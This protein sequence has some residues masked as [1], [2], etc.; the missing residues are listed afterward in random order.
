MHMRKKKWSRPELE[1]C[2]YFVANPVQLRN[3][4]AARFA[5]QQP[6]HIE[7]GCGK[8][9]S[10]AQMTSANRQINYLAIDINLDVLGCARRNLEAAYGD[11]PIENALLTN[12][13]I[14]YIHTILGPE[15]RVERIYISFCNPWC[16]RPKQHKRRLTHPRQLMQYREFLADGGEIWFKTDDDQLFRDSLT[17][18]S[19]C[20]FDAAYL[21]DDLHGSGFA[22]NYVSEYE[23]KYLASGMKIHFGIFRK[24]PGKL[25]LDAVAWREW[26]MDDMDGEEHAVK[27]YTVKRVV[28][29]DFGCEGLPDGEEL[30]VTLLLLNAEGAPRR[31]RMADA[32]A[33]ALGIC[34]GTRLAVH[35]DGAI[36]TE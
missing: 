27:H 34:E 24:R 18:F 14:E 20:G 28:E 22:P 35:A 23:R 21:T 17:Y 6:F 31:L 9:V 4:W 8:G 7:L 33:Q 12:C 25:E 5:H 19:V 26:E 30:Q 36:T 1:A 32:Q 11:D 10:T 29:D 3:A 13:H 2:P 16:A 15:D